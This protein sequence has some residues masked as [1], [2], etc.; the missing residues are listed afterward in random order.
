MPRS[1]SPARSAR[2]LR[3]PRR[4][5]SSSTSDAEDRLRLEV[6]RDTA[7]AELAADAGLLEAAE[8]GVARDDEPVDHH[9]ARA[10]PARD[11]AAVRGVAGGD[12]SDQAIWGVIGDPD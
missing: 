6:R 12:V 7:T 1:G 3:C 4:S 2:C 11:L 9:A 8:R 5:S 10:D